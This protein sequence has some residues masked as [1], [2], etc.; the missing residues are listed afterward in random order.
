M[1]GPSKFQHSVLVVFLLLA[2]FLSMPLPAT[3]AV[4]GMDLVYN[5]SGVCT[6]T[7]NNNGQPFTG[8]LHGVRVVDHDN[9]ISG[10]GSSHIVTVTYPAS[11]P[12]GPKTER[13]YPLSPT[14]CSTN[15]CYYEFYDGNVDQD[16]LSAC[17]GTYT[18]RVEEAGEPTSF[19]EATDEL[20]VTPVGMLDESSFSP[21]HDTPQAITAYFDDVYVNGSLYDDFSTGL[22][23]TRW[24]WDSRWVSSENG[25]A[26][27]HIEFNPGRGSYWLSL[28]NPADVTELKSTVRVT[29]M[30]GNLPEARIG[31]TTIRDNV[32]NIW[33]SVRIQGNEATY[34]IGPE[35]TDGNHY[36][37]LYYA[38]NEAM[39]PV[40]TGNRYQ[41][42]L[43]WDVGSQTY[44]FKV[45]GLDDSVNY[46]A[47][48]TLTGPLSPALAPSGGLSVSGYVM[49]S[50]TPEFNWT[51]VAGASHY[52]IRIYGL[53]GNHIWWGY[54]KNPPYKL[55]PGIL[56][57]NSF[58]KYRIQAHNEHQW[59]DWENV[60][61]S[62]QELTRFWTPGE[63]AQ[64][65]YVD[66]ASIGAETWSNGIFPPH[67][68]FYVK[69]YDAQGV[70]QNIE[71]VQA[72]VPGVGMVNLQFDVN[73]GANC[74][75]YRG[76][77]FGA[78]PLPS[79]V[80]T[81]TATDKDGNTHSASDTLHPSPIDLAAE[82]SLVPAD[83]IVV[84]NT[85]VDF[86]WEDIPGA[87]QYELMIYDENLTRITTLR[88][89]LSQA[90][91]PPGILKENAYYRYRV[92]AYREF[93][94]DIVSNGS[95]SPAGSPYDMHS[96]F[97]S[98]LTASTPPSISIGKFGVAIWRAPHPVTGSIYNL[99]YSA[100][101]SQPEGIPE[102]IRSVDVTFPDGVTKKSLKFDNRETTWGFNYFEDETYTTTALI[103]PGTYSFT[104]TDFD[105]FT[106]G[107]VFDEL[108]TED[109]AAAAVFG[110]PTITAPM[111][112]SV[113]GSTNPTIEWIAVSD[114][115][116]YQVRVSGG[117]SATSEV[118]ISPNI[119]TGTS[120]TL[121]TGI[122]QPNR[123]YRVRVYAFKES[124]GAAPEVDLYSGSSTMSQ[125]DLHLIVPDTVT[126]PNIQVTPIDQNT[127]SLP[128]TITFDQVSSPGTTT[129]ASSSSGTPPPSGFALGYPPV[130]YEIGTTAGYSGNIQ[131]CFNYSGTYYE[132]ENELKL[133]HYEGTAWVDRT[134]LP[135]DTTNNIICGNVTTLSPFALFEP[136][137]CKGDL[138]LHEDGDVDGSDL[139]RF[140]VYFAT[141]NSEGDF[142]GD[143]AVDKSDLLIFLNNFGHNDCAVTP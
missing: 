134:E 120:Y 121:P 112:F 52:R 118:H 91:L 101:V 11:Y 108:T 116:Y 95:N 96:F 59:F 6:W 132:N 54:A 69:V 4:P 21:K 47:S 14:A 75:L 122:L 86:D 63:E 2:V 13:L 133:Y 68:S 5:A 71:S 83:N 82:A 103:Q 49:T 72:S 124:L 67:V 126:G 140:A 20:N 90:S 131:V 37:G 23:S 128:A 40:T 3:A 105:G 35:R 51:P 119:T 97:T 143:N 85:G 15:G 62:D 123:T 129:L 127:G 17:G 102:T 130:Y 78:Q 39:G 61:K 110:W 81:I 34:T 88:S 45:K 42:S 104:V 46:S 19:S 107:P 43:S 27:F 58:Y 22:N 114:A 16:N 70:P 33:A 92:L 48:Y 10:D 98:G 38:L 94:E 100:L 89:T 74:G 117:Y 73:E 87:V 141:N 28:S 77:Y 99:E 93:F 65:P 50:T 30:T 106:Y 125:T 139:A 135:I 115:S 56:K 138:D 136:K 76:D 113:L 60:S 79:G 25:Q 44:T 8:I 111:D 9:S 18:Y 137:Y 41:L 80:Y 64:A 31:T 7:T 1:R 84:G 12:D 32:G 26:K 55:P 109:I 57:P 29:N 36:R 142:T 53:N 24:S 66:L